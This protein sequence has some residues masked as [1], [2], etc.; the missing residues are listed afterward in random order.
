MVLN[1]IVHANIGSTEIRIFT[2]STC[3]TLHSLH[4]PSGLVVFEP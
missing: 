4:A 1:T 2:C 3:V